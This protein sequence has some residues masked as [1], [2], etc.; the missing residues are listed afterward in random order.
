MAAAAGNVLR[1]LTIA[2]Q[3]RPQKPAGSGAKGDVYDGLAGRFA[4]HLRLSLGNTGSEDW[5]RAG[6][7]CVRTPERDG[8]L[9]RMRG[10]LFAHAA[11]RPLVPEALERVELRWP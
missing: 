5:R 1:R 4:R 10:S 7:D 2:Y 11:A 3:H 8:L 9:R 6:R